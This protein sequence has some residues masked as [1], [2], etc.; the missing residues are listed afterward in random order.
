[1]EILSTNSPASKLNHSWVILETLFNRFLP[2]LL[3][4]IKIS[5][6]Y[7]HHG[8]SKAVCLMPPIADLKVLKTASVLKRFYKDN[9]PRH[10][11]RYNGKLLKELMRQP[12]DYSV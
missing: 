9:A 10:K 4:L 11:G 12:G 7:Y 2:V 6:Y 8:E 1:M 5:Y 3:N